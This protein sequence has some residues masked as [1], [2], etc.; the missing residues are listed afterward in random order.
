MNKKRTGSAMAF[1]F[2]MGIVS[3]FGDMTHEGARSIFGGYLSL[4]GASAAAIGF[5]TGFGELVGYSLRFITGMIAD[6]TKKYWTMTI[7][8]YATNVIAI[9]CLALVPANGWVLAAFFI[10]LERMGKALR[11]PA[12]NTLLSFAASQNGLGKGFAIQEFMDQIGA[13]LGPVI[14]FAVMAFREG[15][16][17][18]NTYEICF[19]VLGIPALCCVAAVLL[20]KRQFPHPERFEPVTAQPQEFHFPKPFWGYLVA[21][22]L[23]AFG[24]M[25]FPLIT[26]HVARTGLLTDDLLPLLYAGAMLV[27][28]VA[29]LL[30]GWLYDTWG[31]KSLMISA[32]LAFPFAFFIFTAQSPA[33]LYLG[34]VLWGIGMGAQESI[35]KSAVSSMIPAQARSTGFGI[36]ETI[37]GVAWFAGSCLLGVLYD[38]SLTLMVVISC[39]MQFLAVPV[40]FY[41]YRKLQA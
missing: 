2:L 22:S 32:L 20:A 7:L 28:A 17:L 23:F 26:M 21:I 14:L 25:D 24:F 40:L 5:I 19:A 6:R 4:L 12:K 11:Q 18:F 33:M 35:F 41:T 39:G 36:F 10:V 38:Q 13:F 16:P 9:P 27:D 37:F 29:A 3:M 1:I 34:V 31:L 15:T 8:G 30:F